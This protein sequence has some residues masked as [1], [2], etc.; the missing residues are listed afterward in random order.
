MSSL[1]LLAGSGILFAVTLFFYA[2]FGYP[3]ILWVLGRIKRAPDSPEEP[4]ASEAWPYVSISLP[5][6]NEAHQTEDLIRSLLAL[7][8]PRDRLQILLVSDASSDGTDDLVRAFEGE[9]IELLRMPERGGKTKAENAAALHLRGEI[10]VNTDASIRIAPDALKPLIAALKDP[11]IG[12]ASGRDVSVPP[13]HRAEGNHGEG[14]RG[15]A[16]ESGYVGYEMMVRDLETR[17][18]SIVGASGCFYAI[19]KTLH[20]IPLPEALSRDFAAALHTRE[21]GLRAVSVPEAVCFVPRTESLRKEFRRKVRTITRGMDTLAYKKALLNPLEYGA[22]S[23]MLFSHKVCRWALPWAAAAGLFSIGVLALSYSLALATLL[24]AF[25]FFGLGL[26]GWAVSERPDPP[27]LFTI[28]A[29]LL[30]GNLAAMR[31]FLRHLRGA[32]QPIWEPTRR[33]RDSSGAGPASSGR[34]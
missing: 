29:Y 26:V 23:W 4:L 34:R 16:G 32:G 20:R 24:A 15:N 19:R 1:N 33:V 30:F 6:Y 31:A 10:V 21:H 17:V 11:L 13:G 18:G 14:G 22:F 9:G 27:R 12:L 8:Y 2:Y 5:V 7:D 25:L 3:V 28:P